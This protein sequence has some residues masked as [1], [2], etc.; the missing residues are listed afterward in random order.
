M[1]NEGD[2]EETGSQ[3]N[4]DT[5]SITTAKC[6]AGKRFQV[7]KLKSVHYIKKDRVLLASLVI[8]VNKIPFFNVINSNL[9]SMC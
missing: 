1:V 8:V 4:D 7:N 2:K 6:K 3:G 5:A 9:Y